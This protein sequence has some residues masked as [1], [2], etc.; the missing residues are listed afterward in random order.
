[1]AAETIAN[2]SGGNVQG[3]IQ[4]N[5]G[6]VNQYFI[7]QV[8]DLISQSTPG[9]EVSFTQVEYR[10]RKFLFSKVKEY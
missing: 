6:T 2:I 9:T 4:E 10:Q 5:H 8:S 1:M 7:S 3:F